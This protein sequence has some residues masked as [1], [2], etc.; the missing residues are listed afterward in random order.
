MRSSFCFGLL[1]VAIAL[2]AQSGTAQAAV[3]QHG[4]RGNAVNFCQAF[5][6]GPANTIRNR[7][8]GSENVGPNPMNVACDF[9]TTSNGAVGTTPPTDLWIYFSN[10]TAA[11]FTVSC[12]LLTGYQGQGSAYAVTKSATIA[13]GSQAVNSLHWAP[14]DNPTAGATSLG[15]VLVGVNCTLPVGAVINDTYLYWNMDNGV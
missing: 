3:A 1:S 6:P 2:A 4:F 9:H 8:V 11:D 14:A 5:T 10:N 12:T 15:N 7:V 13:A